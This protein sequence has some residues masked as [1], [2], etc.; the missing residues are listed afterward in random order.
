MQLQGGGEQGEVSWDLLTFGN[1]YIVSN[2]I[3]DAE[4]DGIREEEIIA[5][6]GIHSK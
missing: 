2:E 3:T 5:E 4:L 6:F 1:I